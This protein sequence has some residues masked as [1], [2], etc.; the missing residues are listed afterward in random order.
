MK[1]GGCIVSAFWWGTCAGC[2][3][4][5]PEV[6][7]VIAPVLAAVRD[8]QGAGHD[9]GETT[10]P[11]WGGGHHLKSSAVVLYGP[12]DL[13]YKIPHQDLSLIDEDEKHHVPSILC[14]I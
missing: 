10:Y 8:S 9:G 12:Q 5:W 11:C 13:E 14:G 1:G 4:T 3:V 6:R 2:E 7:L